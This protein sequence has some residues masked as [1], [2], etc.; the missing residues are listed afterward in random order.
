MNKFIEF[1]ESYNKIQINYF[2]LI[3][4][5]K[6]TDFDFHSNNYIDTKCNTTIDWQK[7]KNKE[8]KGSNY[9]IWQDKYELFEP[10]KFKSTIYNN[11]VNIKDIFKEKPLKH[12]DL[13]FDSLDDIINILENNPYDDN[14]KYNFDLQSLSLIKP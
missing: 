3:D 12:I 4:I 10:L 11:D 8:K 7:L 13:N 9:E 1:L 5:L 2:D 6:A 14:F